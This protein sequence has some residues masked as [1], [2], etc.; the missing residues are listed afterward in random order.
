[1]AEKTRELIRVMTL[2]GCKRQTDRPVT[3]HAPG[4]RTQAPIA[5]HHSWIHT[6]VFCRSNEHE[7]MR[8]ALVNAV[9]VFNRR[10][11]E[12]LLSLGPIPDDRFGTVNTWLEQKFCQYALCHCRTGTHPKN[13]WVMKQTE[14]VFLLIISAADALGDKLEHVVVIDAASQAI[15]DCCEPHTLKM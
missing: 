6:S 13:D 10:D 5:Q 9:N 11:A 14:R 3:V 4:N 8:A 1:M 2:S 7:C 15:I 12:T